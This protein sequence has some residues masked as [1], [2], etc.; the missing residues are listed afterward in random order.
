MG[1]VVKKLSWLSCKNCK[2]TKRCMESGIGKWFDVIIKVHL[3]RKGATRNGKG[4][5]PF[6]IKT[7]VVERPILK[8]GIPNLGGAL[9]LVASLLFRSIFMT[10]HM[11][12]S[13]AS[14]V[15]CKN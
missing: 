8:L 15:D 9:L 6:Y 4:N 3:K 14:F 10:S 12:L 2:L 1:N 7:A 11:P 5:Q 13:R